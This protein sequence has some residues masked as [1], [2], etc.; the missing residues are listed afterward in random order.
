MYLKLFL[1]LKNDAS[2]ALSQRNVCVRSAEAM[3][4]VNRLLSARLV[5]R[6]LVGPIGHAL[7][8]EN[9][10]FSVRGYFLPAMG[11]GYQFISHIPLRQHWRIDK[12]VK[13]T[14]FRLDT[15]DK[16]VIF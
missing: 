13:F 5:Y 3:V 2:P 1:F 15:F 4:F 16:C 12:Q 8:E 11:T 10:M 7:V 9:Q 6:S 14:H